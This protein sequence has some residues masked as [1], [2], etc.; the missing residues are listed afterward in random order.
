MGVLYLDAEG[1][2]ARDLGHIVA[3]IERTAEASRRYCEEIGAVRGSAAVE[4]DVD[5]QRAGG[6]G[7]CPRWLAS[8]RALGRSGTCAAVR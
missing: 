7:G 5:M 6:R 2:E 1:N 4:D 3:T 8:T